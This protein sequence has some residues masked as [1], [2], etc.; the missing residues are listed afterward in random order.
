LFDDQ[1]QVMRF[2]ITVNPPGGDLGRVGIRATLKDEGSGQV[3]LTKNYPVS[4]ANFVAE[5]DGSLMSLGRA[6]QV[7]FSVVDPS[8]GSV[9]YNYPAYRVSKAP[10]TA[11]SSMNISFDTKNR[12]LIRGTPRFALGVY[13]SGMG[14]GSDDA[15][16][17]NA[18]WSPTGDR[19]LSGLRINF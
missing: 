1:P 3:L 7:V 4:A 17:E 6:Y 10:G 19:R 16:W 14:Y 18:I 12:L 9:T 15:F 8:T 13:D 5:L 2:D 11:R